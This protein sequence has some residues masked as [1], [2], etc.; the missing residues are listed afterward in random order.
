M[1][2]PLLLLLMMTI[3]MTIAETEIAFFRDMQVLF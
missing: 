2:L 1:W 3:M